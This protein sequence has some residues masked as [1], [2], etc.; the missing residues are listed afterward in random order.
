MLLVN[1]DEIRLFED[2]GLAGRTRFWAAP[3]VYEGLPNQHREKVHGI[4]LF[5]DGALGMWT[6]ALHWPYRDA[7]QSGMLLYEPAELAAILRRYLTS[8]KPVAVHAIGDRAIDQA[9]AAIESAGPSPGAEVRIEHAQFIAEPVARRARALGVRLCMQTNFSDDSVHYASRLPDGYAERNNPFRMLI[10]QV[11]FRPG[12]DLLF[13]SD[14]MPHGVSEGL[15]QALFPPYDGQRLTLDEFVA[16]YCLPDDR[17]GHVEVRVDI[18]SRQVTCH[19]V[20]R[21]AGSV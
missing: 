21:T 2:A 19:V 7:A 9:V 14:G 20:S 12:Q 6:A 15:R 17:A 18:A 4:K 16:G 11:G 5:T 3:D 13:G 1:G 8:G 10:D